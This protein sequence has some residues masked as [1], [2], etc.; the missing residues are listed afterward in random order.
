MLNIFSF[1]CLLSKKSC[2]LAWERVMLCKLLLNLCVSIQ[3]AYLDLFFPGVSNAN[4][5]PANIASFDPWRHITQLSQKLLKAV[6]LIPARGQWVVIVVVLQEVLLPVVQFFCYY[7][8][9]KQNPPIDKQTGYKFCGL[10]CLPKR[11]LTFLNAKGCNF[12]PKILS[13]CIWTVLK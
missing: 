11:F 2:S 9:L 1:K 6:K 3:L 7:L 5:H 8:L 4:S 13:C 12:T 10:A